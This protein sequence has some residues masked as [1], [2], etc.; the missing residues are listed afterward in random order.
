MIEQ[1]SI[2]VEFQTRKHCPRYL[3]QSLAMTEALSN[4]LKYGLLVYVTMK[5][6]KFRY[7]N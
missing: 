3:L 1:V 4:T 7:G 2:K 6:G 5:T